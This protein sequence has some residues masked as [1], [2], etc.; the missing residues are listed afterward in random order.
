MSD[1]S[2]YI[3]KGRELFRRG[4]SFRDII[5]IGDDN[6][7]NALF[8]GFFEAMGDSNRDLNAEADEQEDF[9]NLPFA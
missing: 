7:R 4:F 1:F 8:M 6:I 9:F 2:F 3:N 5:L